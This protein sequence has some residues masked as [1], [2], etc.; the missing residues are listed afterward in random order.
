MKTPS[1]LALIASSALALAGST[2]CG[3]AAP[4]AMSPVASAA[5]APAPAALERS[6]F[7]RDVTGSVGEN[8]L[9]RILD[10]R[11]DLTFPVRVGVVSLDDAFRAESR[12]AVGEQGIMSGAVTR[13]LKGATHFSHVTDVSTEL[14][15]PQGLEG[16]RTIAAR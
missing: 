14:P 7:S 16:L 1:L 15:N 13:S 8:E 12:A 5:Q 6:L 3:A 11:M 4:R 9:Q 2:G 10:S